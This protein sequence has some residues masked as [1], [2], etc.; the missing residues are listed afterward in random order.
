MR[1]D[2]LMYRRDAFGETWSITRGKY[3]SLAQHVCG[4]AQENC[5]STVG[6][7]VGH[8]VLS[9]CQYKDMSATGF[10]PVTS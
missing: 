2:H 6:Q 7:D 8:D 1:Y 10:K 5:I 9:H 4:I 3:H